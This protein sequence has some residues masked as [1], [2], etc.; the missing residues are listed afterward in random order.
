VLG[1]STTVSTRMVC[2]RIPDAGKPPL[3]WFRIWGQLKKL[4][5]PCFGSF[6]IF[7]SLAF[8]SDLL[9]YR[10]VLLSFA[11]SC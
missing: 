5:H 8:Y 2:W 7:S 9:R 3:T 6:D 11:S 1:R 4:R 10:I